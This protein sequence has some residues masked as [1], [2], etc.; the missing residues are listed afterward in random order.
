MNQPTT[1]VTS[2]ARSRSSSGRRVRPAGRRG[3]LMLLAAALMVTACTVPNTVL[4]KRADQASADGQP[5]RAQALLEQAL[6]QDR[7]DW[8]AHHALGRILLEGD[9]LGAQ[10]HLERALTLQPA[11]P[12]APAMTEALAEALYR[13]GKHEQA[14]ALLEQAIDE[15]RIAEA[16]L[17]LGRYAAT[18]G[19]AD[20]AVLAFRQAAAVAEADD[21]E[22]YMVMWRYYESIGDAGN[23]LKSLRMAYGLRP[24]DPTL[25]LALRRYGIVPGPT[26]A[27]PPQR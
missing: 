5:Q 1:Y 9:P 20:G 16:Y 15:Q 23:A 17:R 7:T 26:A 22:P 14:L 12:Q 10:L 24:D 6:E 27:L 11:G 18:I 21:V 19:D 4:R 13:Q 3:V 8:Q 25:A 2:D